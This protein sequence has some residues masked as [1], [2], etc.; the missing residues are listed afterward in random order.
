MIRLFALAATSASLSLAAPVHA[1]AVSIIP[2]PAILEMREGSF[3]L[4]PRTTIWATARTANLARQ[5]EAYLE[6]ATGF[7]IPVRTSGTPAGNRIVLRIDAALT[8]LGDEGYTLDIAYLARPGRTEI[9]LD[10]I[11]DYRSNV[12]LYPVFQA[13]LRQHQPPLL[14]AWGRNDAHFVPAG[15]RAYR[16]DVRDAEIHFVDAGHF[17]RE[18]HAADIGALMLDFLGRVLPQGRR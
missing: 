6:P 2:R 4:T 11:L 16:T 8:R 5:L 7:D 3:S 17:A 9:Q 15:A 10:L 14:A 12:A 18:T 13:Y 1:Q